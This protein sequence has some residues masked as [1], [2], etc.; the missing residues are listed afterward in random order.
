MLSLFLSPSISR[1]NLLCFED[2]SEEI[3]CDAMRR[4]LVRPLGRKYTLTKYGRH[5]AARLKSC[6]KRHK[7]PRRGKM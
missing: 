7:N 6:E 2:A 3:F 4:R 1:G 5:Q